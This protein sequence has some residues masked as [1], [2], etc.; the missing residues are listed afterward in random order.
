[1]LKRF[2]SIACLLLLTLLAAT[3]CS[4]ASNTTSETKTETQT[5]NAQASTPA[6]TQAGTG[7][8]ATT[9]ATT[10]TPPA[11]V[12]EVK[13]YLVAVGD[14]GKKGKKIGCEDSLIAVTRKIKPTEAPLKAAIEEL[15]STQ[16]EEDSKGLSNYWWGEKL[17]LKSVSI[18]DGAA[19][20]H[21]TGEGPYVAG[22]CD[23]PRITEQIEETAKQFPT[24]KSVKVF[25][26]GKPLEE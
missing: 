15:L 26:N 4:P 1:M 10:P 14:N 11:M 23:V 17:K 8:A 9:A 3:A 22:I 25:V 19:T 18:T 2:Y 7:T 24:V 12:E 6:A 21:I 13:I 20:I 16:H 5:T